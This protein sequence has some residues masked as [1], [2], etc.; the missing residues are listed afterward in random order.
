MEMTR[1]VIINGSMV[2]SNVPAYAEEP[3]TWM[4]F[5]NVDGEN[6]FWGGFSDRDRAAKAAS[7]AGGAAVEVKSVEG[8]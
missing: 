7:E 5:R 6:W 3:G 8:F 2:V 1:K 4:V